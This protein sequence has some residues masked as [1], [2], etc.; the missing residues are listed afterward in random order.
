MRRGKRVVDQRTGR[1]AD[2]P[3][4]LVYREMVANRSGQAERL[5]VF[6][7]NGPL[8]TDQGDGGTPAAN[9]YGG[10]RPERHV[11]EH[12]RARVNMP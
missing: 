7:R 1:P 4:W 3:E 8:L 5:F 10:A 12:I 9:W 2:A 11:S 6:F